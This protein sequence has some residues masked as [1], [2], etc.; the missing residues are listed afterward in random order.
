MVRPKLVQIRAKYGRN[1]GRAAQYRLSHYLRHKRRSRRNR[2]RQ[3]HK[4]TREIGS[5]R[6]SSHP[7]V[8]PALWS[9]VQAFWS[10]TTTSEDSIRPGDGTRWRRCG[11]ASNIDEFSPNYSWNM[12]DVHLIGARTAIPGMASSSS[13]FESN[14]QSKYWERQEQ[15]CMMEFLYSRSVGNL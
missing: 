8:H 5:L 11:T 4:V 15:R 7:R 6:A 13:S 14:S 12:I 10:F 3:Q 2:G 1:V 9:V